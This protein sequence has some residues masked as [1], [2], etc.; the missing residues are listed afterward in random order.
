MQK[1]SDLVFDDRG[2]ILTGVAVQVNLAGTQTPATIY[3]DNGVTPKSNPFIN[4]S[5]GT[6]K[7]Y[8]ANG[9][10]D[11]TF[12]KTGYTFDV[13]DL[14]DMLFLDFNDLFSAK[15]QFIVG[16]GNKTFAALTA[17]ADRLRLE[18][19]AAQTTGVRGRNPFVTS[20][21]NM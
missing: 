4:E 8:V 11:M 7:F 18:Y 21:L 10:Y 20:F 17:A 13:T 12:L 16:T 5:D 19:D 15:G 3:S 9:R 14:A 1:Y 6:F 2:Q